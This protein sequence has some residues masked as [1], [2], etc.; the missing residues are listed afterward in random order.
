MRI[1][2]QVSSRQPRVFKPGARRWKLLLGALPWHLHLA[3]FSSLR[4]FSALL[5]K[6]IL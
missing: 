5:Q 6:A 3:S 2:W 4:A 1:Y